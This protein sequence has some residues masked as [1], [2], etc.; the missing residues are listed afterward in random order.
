MKKIIKIYLPLFYLLILIPFGVFGQQRKDKPNDNRPNIIYIL[1]DDVGFSDLQPYGSE[2]PTP[3]IDRLAKEGIRYNHFD[4]KAICSSTRAAL[5]TGRNNQAVGM[6]DLAWCHCTY[7]G[8]P[9]NNGYITPAAATVAQILKVNGYRTSAVGKWHLTP[10]EQ[11]NDTTTNKENWPT[12]KGFEHFY[13]WLAGWTDQFQPKGLGREIMEG[14]HAVPVPHAPGYD[15]EEA[16]T[17]HA[18]DYLQEG[19]KEHPD[20]PEFLYFA[21]GAAHAPYQVPQ[22]YIDKFNGVY[23]QGWD[24]L[25]EDRF[26]RQKKLGIIPLNAVLTERNPGDPAWDS[27]TQVQKTV[28]ARFMAAYAGY[29]TQAD[30]QIGRLINFLKDAGQYDNTLIF[31]M[32]DNG[33]A[34]EAGLEGGFYR[35]YGDTTSVKQM[36]DHL[37]ELGTEQT[38]I[39]YQ[40]PWAMLGD[41]PFKRYKLWPNLGGVR[42]PLIISWPDGI[43][44]HGAIRSQYVDVIDITPTAINIVGITA[45]KVL[46]GVNQMDY[47]GESIHKTF[48]DPNAPTRDV[49]FYD[50]RDNRAI[51]EGGWRAVAI[52]KKGTSFNDDQWELYHLA[53]DFSEA[54]DLAKQYPDKLKALKEL[55]WSEAKKND[56]LPLKEIKFHY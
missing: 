18:I 12:G 52:H 23:E 4:T 42:D 27:L 33:A 13:G 40:R 3:N 5:L 37:D 22:R 49:Q 45:P 21:M 10:G 26:E 51:R 54:I 19:F 7:G 36:L 9:Y 6:M 15:V 43:L 32:S 16:I 8:Y 41:T 35:P 56:A 24:K 55:W 2:I 48:T 1:L 30:E 34:P 25:R 11:L 20:Q 53:N 17:D 31:F 46:D 44:D 28:F 14:T 39:L 38:Q 47:A 50:M 29:I